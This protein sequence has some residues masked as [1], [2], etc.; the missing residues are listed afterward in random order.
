MQH[1]LEQ[2]ELFQEDFWTSNVLKQQAQI[3]NETTL[4]KELNP[5]KRTFVH[6]STLERM[7]NLSF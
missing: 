5:S 6:D 1:R 3:L 4:Q 7:I 2:E